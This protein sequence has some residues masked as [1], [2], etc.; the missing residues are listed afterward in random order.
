MTQTQRAVFGGIGLLVA[1][2]AFGNVFGTIARS[3]P[4]RMLVWGAIIGALALA[5]AAYLLIRLV[6]HRRG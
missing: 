4:D 6:Q 1:L 3:G 5:S 2:V